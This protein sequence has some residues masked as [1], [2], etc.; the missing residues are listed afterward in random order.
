MKRHGILLAALLSS[1]WS[2]HAAT[3]IPLGAAQQFAVLGASTV[4]NTGP[5]V[6]HGDLGVWPGTAITGFP[7]GAFSG[8]I[9]AGD[10]VAMQAQADA[11]TAYNNAAGQ[12]ANTVL[13]GQD[14]GGLTLTPG[15]YS[16]ASSAQLT[17]TLILDAIGNPNAVFIFQIGST[18]TTASNSVVQFING[19]QGADLFWQVGSSETLGTGTLFA[20][21][22]LA[23]A[24]IT[25]NTGASINCGRAIALNGAVTL[26][27]N[28]IGTGCGGSTGGVPEPATWA[29]L[30]MGFGALGAVLRNNRRSALAGVAA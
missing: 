2:V 25:M 9:H 29:M 8:T 17:G 14:L 7:P 19:G 1:A 18:L 15:V 4:T 21:T 16:F 11:T 30:T 5:T 12:A 13:T 26:D 20:G 6:L 10:A 22:T 23:L 28:A 27:S 24:S 3:T